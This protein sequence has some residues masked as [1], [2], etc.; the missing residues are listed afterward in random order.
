MGMDGG[1]GT[2]EVRHTIQRC[3]RNRST[4]SVSTN[5]GKVLGTHYQAY[6]VHLSVAWTTNARRH[7][8][9]ASHPKARYPSG[10][11]L[12]TSDTLPSPPNTSAPRI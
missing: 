7:H 11:T 12:T 8:T 4:S 10:I 6:F 3:M 1:W 9:S 2:E 5:D